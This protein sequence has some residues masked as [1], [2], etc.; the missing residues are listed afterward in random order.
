MVRQDQ[1]LTTSTPTHLSCTSMPKH[2]HI[3]MNERVKT[4]VCDWH[5]VKIAHS[6]LDPCPPRQPFPRQCLGRQ[7]QQS[8]LRVCVHA[9]ATRLA[10]HV[11]AHVTAHVT[12]HVAAHVQHTHTCRCTCYTLSSLA[13]MIHTLMTH[14]HTWH[15]HSWHTHTSVGVTT[16]THTPVVLSWHKY[17]V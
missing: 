7:P 6:P 2:T 1:R 15:P 17:K 10:A 13:A 3:H 12:A 14:T 9:V 11:A 4:G 8:W 5:K 16:H